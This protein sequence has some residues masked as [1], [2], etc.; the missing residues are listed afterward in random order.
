M[1]GGFAR[2]PHTS[3]EQELASRMSPCAWWVFS[4]ISPVPLLNHFLV[5]FELIF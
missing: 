1:A 4:K 5:S 2:T 3:I